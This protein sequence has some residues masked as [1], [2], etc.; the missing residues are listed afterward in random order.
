MGWEA[1]GGGDFA[2][3]GSFF[4]S[5]F[6]FFSGFSRVLA[7]VGSCSAGNWSAGKWVAACVRAKQPLLARD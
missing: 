1:G 2:V 6:W 7:T 3:S 4:E 5:C